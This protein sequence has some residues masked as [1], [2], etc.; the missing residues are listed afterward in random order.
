MKGR[1]ICVLCAG[2]EHWPPT[3]VDDVVLDFG[4]GEVEGVGGVGPFETIFECRTKRRDDTMGWLMGLPDNF[5]EV[6]EGV[7]DEH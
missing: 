3:G 2:A 7:H 6:A 4:D 1:H 5:E